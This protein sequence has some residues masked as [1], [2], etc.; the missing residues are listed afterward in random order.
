MSV[1]LRLLRAKLSPLLCK[2]EKGCTAVEWLVWLHCREQRE[3]DPFQ[4]GSDRSMG[5]CTHTWLQSA[6]GEQLHNFKG[7]PPLS[8]SL[9]SGLD[10]GVRHTVLRLALWES[11]VERTTGKKQSMRQQMG[12]SSRPTRV[13]SFAGSQ[14]TFLRLKNQNNTCCKI[15]CAKR[16]KPASHSQNTSR[17]QQR[18]RL[19]HQGKHHIH[20]QLWSSLLNLCLSNFLS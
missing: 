14:V 7:I 19:V 15:F 17:V 2:W 11:Q 16:E 10:M 1:I 8:F 9:P 3:S 4:A 6:I 13:W 12:L 20:M 18:N 5:H